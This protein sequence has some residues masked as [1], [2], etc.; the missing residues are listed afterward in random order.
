MVTKAARHVEK[1][2][3]KVEEIEAPLLLCRCRP[4][5]RHAMAG[6]PLQ[7]LLQLHPESR[8]GEFD[9]NLLACAK[10]GQRYTL[11]D[12][13]NAQVIRR[14][15]AIAWN[16][17]FDK[18]DLLL[19]PT[20]AVQPFAVGKNLPRRARRQGQHAVVALHRRSST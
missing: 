4:R 16:L 18:Y 3:C 1:L 11:Q 8:H 6:Q 14:E 5:L 2:G 15:L 9:P 10:A 7:R 13:V 17:F 12:V 20:V 19:S